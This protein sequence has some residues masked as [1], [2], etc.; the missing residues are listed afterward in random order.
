MS[1]TKIS[2]S[3]GKFKRMLII[4]K[5]TYNTLKDYWL[6][7]LTGILF[8]L[9]LM[10]FIVVAFIYKSEM[11]FVP[12]IYINN[13]VNYL[14]GAFLALLG[15]FISEIYWTRKNERQETNRHI[16]RLLFYLNHS[17]GIIWKTNEDL[18][19]EINDEEESSQRDQESLANLRRLGDC[20]TNISNLINES[21]LFIS[22]NKLALRAIMLFSSNVANELR[23]LSKYS[24]IRPYAPK[25][26][27]QLT[28]TGNDV[29]EIVVLLTGGDDDLN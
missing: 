25:I 14:M 7:T 17:A 3:K 19:K 4:L 8:I 21:G 26:R 5:K 16:A 18:A 15:F 12:W 27:K 2:S 23:E 22:K 28:Q 13:G 29:H 11:E 9:I 6:L 1:Q 24:S 20:E 10:S